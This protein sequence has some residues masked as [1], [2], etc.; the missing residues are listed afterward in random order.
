M[1]PGLTRLLR[2]LQAIVAAVQLLRT[3]R[4]SR[5][6]FKGELEQ[7]RRTLAATREELEWE[8]AVSTALRDLSKPLISVETS[9]G[10]M[11]VAVLERARNL[12][13]SPQGYVSAI[14]TAS[15]VNV[16]HTTSPVVD[17]P[18][19][20]AEKGINLGRGPDGKY[21]GLWGHALNT[22]KPFLTNRPQE[23]SSAGG[24]PSGH[25]EIERFLTVP[26]MLDGNPAGQIAVANAPRDY[27]GRDIEAL[28][29]LAR[30]YALALQRKESQQRT[31]AAL[32]EKEVLLREIHHRVKNN[33]QVISSLLNL[34]AGFIKDERVLELLMDSQNRV[35]SMALVHEQLHRSKD[36]SKIHFGDY[37]R[38]LAASLFSAYGV[39]S[40]N[41]GL[42]LDVDEVY[43]GIDMAIPCGLIIHELASNSLRHGFPK[44]RRGEV[45][46]TVRADAAAPREIVVED[47]GVGLKAGTDIQ[48]T[49]SL[50][51]RLVHILA[52]QMEARVSHEEG[53]ATRFRVTIPKP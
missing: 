27:T 40:S 21:T 8:L 45:R 11:A 52:E 37:V 49:K 22:G 42:H 18:C 12:T 30:F 38:N 20:I 5:D 19:Q 29:R 41:V 1:N 43:L 17:G 35:R 31:D 47:N 53:T 39:R 24:Y 13:S 23:H 33:L 44:G 36:L 10:N 48:N 25:I 32:R 9:L 16:G 51:L 28:C 46:I 6:T 2:V 26:L 7:M 3:P 14:D 50:G 34:Q 4:E 15:G